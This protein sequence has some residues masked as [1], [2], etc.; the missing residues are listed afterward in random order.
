MIPY[1]PPTFIVCHILQ[2]KEQQVCT[3]GHCYLKFKQNNLFA[4]SILQIYAVSITI[5]I[6][7][8][9]NLLSKGTHKGKPTC[10]LTVDSHLCLSNHVNYAVTAWFPVTCT[11]LE[12]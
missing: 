3:A 8:S 10:F 1:R 6:V 11:D 2:A 5:R 9:V 12:I 7:V 4:I